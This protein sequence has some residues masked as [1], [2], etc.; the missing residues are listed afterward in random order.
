[1]QGVFWILR[2]FLRGNVNWYNSGSLGV[3]SDGFERDLKEIKIEIISYY[4]KQKNLKI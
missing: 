1:M 3:E 4:F 2:G